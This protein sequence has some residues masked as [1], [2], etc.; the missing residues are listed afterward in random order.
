MPFDGVGTDI[1]VPAGSD[2]SSYQYRFMKL[3]TSGYATPC[4]AK[5]DVVV[6]ILQNKPAAAGRGARIR[7]SG[8]S[9]MYHSAANAAA[10]TL[11]PCAVGGGT[12]TTTDSVGAI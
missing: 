7:I 2:L 12:A 1:T 9:L 11:S 6:G 3:D 8:I 4:S 5:T 10:T